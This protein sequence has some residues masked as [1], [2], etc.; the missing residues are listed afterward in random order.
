MLSSLSQ[1]VIHSESRH[2]WD[3]QHDASSC[4][5]CTTKDKKKKKPNHRTWKY[6]PQ[7]K[8]NR[9]SSRFYNGISPF[10]T[11]TPPFLLPRALAHLRSYNAFILLTCPSAIYLSST[12]ALPPL[13]W[14][15]VWGHLFPEDWKNL[16]YV[17][18]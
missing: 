3:K 15:A 13:H 5:G 18:F 10:P 16:N 8:G 1:Y 6:F 14:A 7:L 9:S 11:K 17:S 2:T 4:K 12:E